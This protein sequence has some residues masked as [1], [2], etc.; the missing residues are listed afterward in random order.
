MSSKTNTP[1]KILNWIF[2]W[3]LSLFLS[4]CAPNSAYEELVIPDGYQGPLILQF[5]CHGGKPLEIRNDKV[6]IE[7]GDDGLACTS[8]EPGPALIVEGKGYSH[9]KSGKPVY[10]AAIVPLAIDEFAI[11]YS[12]SGST[13]EPPLEDIYYYSWWYG[14][15]RKVKP[16]KINSDFS[17]FFHTHYGYKY[18]NRTIFNPH[19]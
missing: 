9:T 7:F 17:D 15:C 11:C 10:S 6:K 16:E 14:P 1:K 3:S 19:P 4:Q 12:A 13:R 2:L 5:R 8:D 18:Y